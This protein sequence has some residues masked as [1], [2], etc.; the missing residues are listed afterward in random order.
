MTAVAA[1]SAHYVSSRPGF[2]CDIQPWLVPGEGDDH[3][4]IVGQP[5]N[6]YMGGEEI[7]ANSIAGQ[8]QWS[9]DSTRVLL[10]GRS[11]AEPPAGSNSYLNQ[12]GTAPSALLIARIHRAP[13]TP[14]A[15]QPT[16]VGAWAPTPQQFRTN[17]DYPG[18]HVVRGKRGGTATISIAGTLM[19][20][21]F[22]VTYHRYS[23]DG[24]YFLSG[25]QTVSGS[26]VAA[27]TFTDDLVA[28]NLL[29]RRV[30]FRSATLT[31]APVVPQPP[32]G[33]P[34]TQMTG[35]VE[36]EWLG[37]TS[38]GLPPVAACPA[39]M[40]TPPPLQLSA[41]KVRAGGSYLVSFLVRSDIAGDRRPVQGATVTVGDLTATTGSTGRTTL[42]VPVG[43]IDAG[44]TAEAT[45][46]DTF[47]P[48]SL[49]IAR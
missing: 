17:L 14:I 38:A 23:N 5:L 37:R 15:A 43:V 40:P 1:M 35:T 39:Q 8:A 44:V 2:A 16:V 7:G 48:A 19:G 24:R 13:T 41:T 32:A 30:G 29:G 11:L 26:I 42:T 33:E 27:T 6:P 46:G 45:A 12:K 49:P 31:V 3:G 22:A 18:V 9:P 10:Q 47:R 28:T 20:G 25:T 34:Q 36:T 4:R 21:E